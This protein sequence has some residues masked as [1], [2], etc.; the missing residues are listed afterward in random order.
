MMR[1]PSSFALVLATT[2]ALTAGLAVSASAQ[3]AADPARTP[4]AAFVAKAADVTSVDA[5]LAT[6]ATTRAR[7]AAVKALA[8]RVL[9][10]R[11]VIARDLQAMSGD[12]QIA[13]PPRPETAPPAA[14]PVAALRAKPPAAFDAAFL[15]ALL[16]NG[17]AA[18]ALFDAE[19]R[20]G[21]D[22]EIK[23]WAARQLPALREHL[24]AIRAMR[25]RPGS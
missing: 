7:S 13:T 19:S 4:D 24:T 15:A 18:V 14:T 25:P 23:E 5:E 9:E 2:L 20:D 16:V 12:R 22:P 10:A 17:E 6:V 3:M 21:R 1:A 8:R 11:T